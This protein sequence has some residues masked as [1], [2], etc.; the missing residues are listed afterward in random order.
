MFS[1]I[2]P[3]KDAVAAAVL[4]VSMGGV[5]TGGNSLLIGQRLPWLPA[6]RTPQQKTHEG[7]KR[8]GSLEHKYLGPALSFS[9][10]YAMDCKLTDHDW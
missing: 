3:V 8:F 7:L 2:K 5:P 4:I 9:K 6:P 1:S 10:R